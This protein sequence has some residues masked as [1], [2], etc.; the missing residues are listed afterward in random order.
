MPAVVENESLTAS[1]DDV[2]AAPCDGG[3]QHRGIC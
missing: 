1:L 3:A 2:V